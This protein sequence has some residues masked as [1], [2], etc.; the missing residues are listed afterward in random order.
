VGHKVNSYL[1]LNV[2]RIGSAA[3]QLGKLGHEHPGQ[4]RARL[5]TLPLVAPA[6]LLISAGAR[7]MDRIFYER[8]E[9][10]GFVIVARHKDKIS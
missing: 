7:V 4:P 5:W 10:L 6:V 8:Q 1:A 9:A 3:Q 2:A